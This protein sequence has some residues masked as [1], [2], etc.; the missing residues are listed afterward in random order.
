[1]VIALSAIA[2]LLLAA[3]IFLYKFSRDMA[4]VESDLIKEIREM[5]GYLAKMSQ[6]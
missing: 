4:I 1:M 3:V 6:K 5:K 2:A